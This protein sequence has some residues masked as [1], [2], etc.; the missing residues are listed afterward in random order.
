M[1][2]LSSMFSKKG[3]LITFLLASISTTAFSQNLTSLEERIRAFKN[4][5]NPKIKQKIKNKKN[6]YEQNFKGILVNIPTYEIFFKGKTFPC[7]VGKPST[8]TKIEEGTIS[9]KRNKIIFRYT[10]GKKAGEIITKS[11]IYDK[12][13][14]KLIKIIDMPY[15]KMRSL[16]INYKKSGENGQLLHSTTNSETMGYAWSHGCIGLTIKDMLELYKITQ[17]NTKIKNIYDPTKIVNNTLLLY[18][19]IYNKKPDIETLILN[20]LPKKIKNK[21]N[22]IA[23]NLLEKQYHTGQFKQKITK[24]PL[25][26]L[27]KH[28]LAYSSK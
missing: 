27:Y 8:P 24:I 18:K 11:R 28:E 17:I 7:R 4:K 20:K 22:P 13:H 14:G 1:S 23:L 21:I 25:K 2:L 10:I 16:V 15:D 12:P 26:Q 6:Q 5:N 3:L 19:D 9:K